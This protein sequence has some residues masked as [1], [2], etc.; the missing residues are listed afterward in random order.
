MLADSLV[1]IKS[2]SVISVTLGFLIKADK[3][4]NENGKRGLRIQAVFKLLG[5]LILSLA[6]ASF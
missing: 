5:K 6:S 3:G 4:I 2:V 1:Q